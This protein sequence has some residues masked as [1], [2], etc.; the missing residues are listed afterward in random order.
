[1]ANVAGMAQNAEDKMLL[2]SSDKG[3]SNSF[4]LQAVEHQAA[5]EAAKQ[6][7]SGVQDDMAKL[8]AEMGQYK[9]QMA[10][11]A[12]KNGFPVQDDMA[13]LMAEMGQYKAQ[14]AAEA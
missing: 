3:A 6:V 11:E 8:M 1:M 5:A 4:D 14:M 10:A 9:A 13:K 7:Q 2:T 12:K